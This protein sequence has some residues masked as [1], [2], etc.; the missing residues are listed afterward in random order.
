MGHERPSDNRA[1]GAAT[2]MGGGFLIERR[3]TTQL[4][5]AEAVVSFWQGCVLVAL[6]SLRVGR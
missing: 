6:V 5:D 3:T 2:Q 4:I 1:G